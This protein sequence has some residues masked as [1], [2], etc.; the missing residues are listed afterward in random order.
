MRTRCDTTYVFVSCIQVKF[1]LTY[2]QSLTDLVLCTTTEV[3]MKFLCL[4]VQITFQIR[5]FGGLS[6]DP[7]TQGTW[8]EWLLSIADENTQS[9]IVV[10]G[11]I[12]DMLQV[13]THAFSQFA[14]RF[15]FLDRTH[16]EFFF[17]I[18]ISFFFFF[19]RLGWQW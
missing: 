8:A 15:R 7:K 5:E 3:F 13:Y 1:L 11:I 18:V 6:M 4:T 16:W 17:V 14:F 12:A 10:A 2:Y 9:D 19:C